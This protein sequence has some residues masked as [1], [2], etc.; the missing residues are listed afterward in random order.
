M[1]ASEFHFHN[2]GTIKFKCLRKEIDFVTDLHY[3]TH[4]YRSETSNAGQGTMIC[5]HTTSPWYLKSV[6][7]GRVVLGVLLIV[8]VYFARS[9]HHTLG[10]EERRNGEKNGKRDKEKEERTRRRKTRIQRN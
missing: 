6:V 9:M 4:L 1:K 3:K 2:H 7:Q 8:C 10:D 5:Y